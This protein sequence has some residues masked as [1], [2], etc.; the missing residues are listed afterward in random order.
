M[1]L[2]FSGQRQS[3]PEFLSRHLNGSRVLYIGTDSR[4]TTQTKFSTV[5]VAYHPGRGG[6]ML[7]HV[8]CERKIEALGERLL[9]E[10]YYSV[11][12]AMEVAAMVPPDVRVEIHLDV[13]QNVKHPSARYLSSVVGLVSAQGF[14]YRVKPDAWC[15][16][17]IADKVVKQF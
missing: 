14:D 6:V 1:Y 3:V 2:T 7:K 13:N 10:A 11:Q 16:T 4:N 12:L 15:A 8:H 17:C 5:L 9:K